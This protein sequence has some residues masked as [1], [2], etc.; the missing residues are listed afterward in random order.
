MPLALCVTV[1]VGV[2]GRKINALGKKRS[3]DD[4]DGDGCGGRG[5]RPFAVRERVNP[6]R[7]LMNGCS[8]VPQQHPPAKPRYIIPPVPSVNCRRGQLAY[9]AAALGVFPNLGAL[10]TRQPGRKIHRS[11]SAVVVAVV[12][13]ALWWL[14]RALDFKGF[15][16]P[17]SSSDP[18]GEKRT[19]R[20]CAG[21]E[22]MEVPKHVAYRV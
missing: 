16:P 21:G 13:Y 17:A 4:R 12:F 8:C 22:K 9:R 2:G 3:T 20:S 10:G 15:V 6:I 19:G 14:R 7:W 18:G 5:T 1:G 11:K